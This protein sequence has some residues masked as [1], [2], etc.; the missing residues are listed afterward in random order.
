MSEMAVAEGDWEYQPMRLPRGMSRPNAATVL[1][2]QAEFAGW[3]LS[4][5]RLYSDGTRQVTL[6]RRRGGATLPV[7]SV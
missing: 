5:V 3:E 2:V 1:A 4:T 6:R 7:L